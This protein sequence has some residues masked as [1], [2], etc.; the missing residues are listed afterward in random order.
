MW[1]CTLSNTIS[2]ST[3]WGTVSSTL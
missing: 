1:C 3:S 2:C